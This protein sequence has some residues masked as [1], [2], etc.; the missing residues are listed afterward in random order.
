MQQT[1]RHVVWGRSAS[2]R[3]CIVDLLRLAWMRLRTKLPSLFRKLWTVACRKKEG[4][5]YQTPLVLDPEP[6]NARRCYLVTFP[7]TDKERGQDGHRL[8]APDNY[9]RSQMKDFVL[10]AIASTQTTRL[11]PLS[12]KYL[13]VFQERHMSEKIHYHVALLG[14]RCFRFAP[15]KASSSASPR[16][17]FSLVCQKLR[18]RRMC[19][20][21]L[22]ALS[23]HAGGTSRSDARTLAWGSSSF[24]RG[25][26][27]SCECS[28]SA[29]FQ[30][31]AKTS[32]R[33]SRQRR[34]SCSWSWPVAHHRPT[35]PRSWW[36]WTWKISCPMPS[37]VVGL[38]W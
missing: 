25:K 21:L 32:A 34:S 18:V 16:L 2:K 19:H 28:L 24:A 1:C 26:P 36:G 27:P 30:R 38:L 8:V 29:G 37:D 7:H 12:L 3:R 5:P 23:F 33:Q 31:E 17:G 35:E 9:T 11:Q 10:G 4:R 22:H 13:S 14:D 6:T 15:P 20:L